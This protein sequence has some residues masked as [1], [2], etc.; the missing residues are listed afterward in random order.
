MEAV[1]YTWSYCPFCVRAK[2][3]LDERGV[4]Y[5]EHVMDAEPEE[6]DRVKQEYGH[7]TVPIVLIDGQFVG[8]CSELEAL[9]RAGRL[10]PA[11]G[12]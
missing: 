3:L 7:P 2:R 12:R 10:Q 8:G 1:L 6:L 4:P 5:T 9:D 11:G